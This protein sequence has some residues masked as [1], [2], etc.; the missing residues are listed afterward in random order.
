MTVRIE[1]TGMHKT[2]LWVVHQE[3]DMH[4]SRVEQGTFSPL[5][6]GDRY[7]SMHAPLPVQA[8]N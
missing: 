1:E 7:S 8:R 2:L 4:D 6:T 3:P 5:G